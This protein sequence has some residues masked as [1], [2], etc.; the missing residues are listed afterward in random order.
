M[1]LLYHILTLVS[2]RSSKEA[3]DVIP[4]TEL[5]ILLTKAFAD[6]DALSLLSIEKEEYKNS[7]SHC[8][9]II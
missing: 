1:Y 4:P 9:R 8:I 7:Y 3:Q 6:K 5:Q 2:T